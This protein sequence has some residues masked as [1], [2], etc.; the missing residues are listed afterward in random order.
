MRDITTRKFQV[1]CPPAVPIVRDVGAKTSLESELRRFDPE[2]RRTVRRLVRENSRY[3]D[4]V[5][6]FPAVLH[7]VA[8]GEDAKEDAIALETARAA[9]E[10]GAALRTVAR[11]LDLPYWLRWLPPDAFRGEIPKV[12]GDATFTRRIATNLP[13][14]RRWAEAWLRSVSFASEAVDESFALWVAG[15]PELLNDRPPQKSLRVLAV[16]AWASTTIPNPDPAGLLRVRWRPGASTSL[17]LCASISWLN[18][19]ELVS[20]LGARPLTPWLESG[21]SG[22]FEI[23]A[24]TTA[25]QILAEARDMSNCIDQ[26]GRQLARSD[27][28]LYAVRARGKSVA[29][30][31]ICPHARERG[32][33]AISQLKGVRNEPAGEDVWRASLGWLSGQPDLKVRPTRAQTRLVEFDQDVWM[34]VFG[35]YFK[36]HPDATWWP[37]R[38]NRVMVEILRDEL[39]RLARNANVFSWLFR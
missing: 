36:E 8:G 1:R 12:P 31:E 16:F 15:R 5:H 23:A 21:T 13:K 6:T 18:R 14:H 28:Q 2:R 17:A 25:D 20:R 26:Y 7:V 38:G 27:T 4:L 11:T 24:L 30:L 39:R 3:A 33:L 9:I 10:D 35:A 19:I 37:R 32:M 29:T 22:P 34:S